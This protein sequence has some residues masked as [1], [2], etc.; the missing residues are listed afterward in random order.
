[1]KSHRN[2]SQQT[3]PIHPHW[4]LNLCVAAFLSV[5]VHLGP[6][7]YCMKLDAKRAV[8][9]NYCKSSCHEVASEFFATIAPDPP[10]WTQNSCFVVFRSVWVHLGPF[11]C[12]MILGWKQ[13]K[14][15]QLMQKFVTQSRIRIFC[16]KSTR[17]TPSDPK[18]MF[19][20]V[21]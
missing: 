2:V 19:W 3:H 6:F 18:L 20:C 21:S 16:N 4:I 13:A 1:M 7:R 10:H 11:R 5:W 12:F 14:L 15:L 9:C 8:W 17:S